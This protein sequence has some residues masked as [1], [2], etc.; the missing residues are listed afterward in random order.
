MGLWRVFPE[1]DGFKTEHGR[2]RTGYNRAR[3]IPGKGKYRDKVEAGPGYGRCK[4][5]VR[6]MVQV[7]LGS[8]Q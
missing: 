8:N 5:K 4:T 1:E 6:K 7:G 3:T 2:D